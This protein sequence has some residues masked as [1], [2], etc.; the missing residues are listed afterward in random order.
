MT[1]RDAFKLWAPAAVRWSAWVRP[2]PFTAPGGSPAQN[3]VLNFT[4]PSIFYVSNPQKDTAI[5]VDTPDYSSVMEGIALAMLGFRPIPLYNGTNG[6]EGAMALVDTHAIE[7]ALLWG[8]AE[9]EEII[10]PTDA[11]PTFLLNSNRTQQY[12]MNVSVFDNSW[13]IYDQDM[14]TAETFL[15]C[16]INKIIVHS[17]KIQ[18]DLGLIL[19]KFQKKGIAIF[20]TNG[21]DAPKEIKHKA[22]RQKLFL[23]SNF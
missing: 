22:S 16:G 23:K 18:K 7:S 1:G 9:L 12:K 15:S 6:Q 4:V 20:L 3:A 17:D 19:S 5:V 21:Y 13:D 10:I 14:P 8:A 11:P 2:V